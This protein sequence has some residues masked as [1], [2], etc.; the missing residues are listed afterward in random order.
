MKQ[1]RIFDTTLRDGEQTPGVHIS[2]DHKIEIA[3]RLESLGVDTI[4][5]GFPASSKGDFAA[6]HDIA[7]SVTECTV[8]ALARCQEN[9]IRTAAEAL[10]GA[11]HPRIHVF[12]ATSDLHLSCKLHM[13]REQVLECVKNS[14]ALARSLCEDV[15]FSAEDA[16]RSD[17]DFLCRVCEEAVANG[18]RT[19]NIPDTVGY[20]TPGAF[21]SLIRYVK[22][23][24][25][26]I[27]NAVISVHCHDDLGLAV[28]NSLAAIE[29]GAGQVEGTVN[30]IGERAGNAALEEIIMA[31]KTRADYY[32]AETRIET[33]LLARTSRLVASLYG[34]DIPRNKAIVGA[35]A[36]SHEAGIHQHGVMADKR[37]YEIMTPES[38]GMGGGMVL[39]KLSG[40]HAFADRIAQLGYT[41]DEAGMTACFTRFKELAD[42]KEV[43][44]ED[45]MALVNDY[46]DSLAAIYELDT[47]QIQSGNKSRAM[48]MVSL[49]C[50]GTTVA[51]AALGD[52][53]IDA[54]FNAI[55]RLSGADKI[56]L[57]EY[58]IK[59]VTEGADALGEATVRIRIDGA[60]YRGRGVS[61]D[62]LEA[63][64]KS[65]LS[66][67]NKWARR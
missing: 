65:Y 20:G 3:K 62:I 41:L 42:R 66:A 27:E 56:H 57:E 61:T 25:S 26:G 46:L 7:A 39:G 24:A 44:D 2:R 8:A 28:A 58:S 1:I 60:T 36:F 22:E 43:S 9:D 55:N 5:A 19:I 35:N 31:L 64:L 40:R 11:A 59:A 12:I 14:V 50:G 33:T 53:P 17:P 18:A 32:D 51:E 21:A 38:V 30:G 45:L 6:L 54:A 13:T 23:H 37:T 67:I 34:L 52:G 10:E 15:E 63:S 4:E 16:S 49:A 29:A 47:F 48:A